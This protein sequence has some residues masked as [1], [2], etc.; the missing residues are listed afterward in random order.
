MAETPEEEYRRERARV[1]DEHRKD[2]AASLGVTETWDTEE[3]QRDF[4]VLG[5]Q[6]PYVVVIRKSDGKKGS[7]QFTHSPRLY[8]GW[9]EHDDG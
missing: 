4:T 8:F 7:L 1:L 2:L 3:L 9:R 5:F 6:A